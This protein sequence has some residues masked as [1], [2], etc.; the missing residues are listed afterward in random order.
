MPWKERGMVDQR[1]KFVGRLLEGDKMAALG[2]EFGISRKTGYKIW[3]RDQQGG[4]EDSP[5]AV[6]ARCD[7]PINFPSSWQPRSYF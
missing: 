3:S 1:L 5:T 7:R 6:D 4:F 2:R